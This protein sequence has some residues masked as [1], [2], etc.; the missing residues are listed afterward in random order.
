MVPVGCAELW[1]FLCL[2][3]LVAGCC[4][5]LRPLSGGVWSWS[6]GRAP[7]PVGVL[8]GMRWLCVILLA[9]LFGLG[10]CFFSFAP[11]FPWVGAR[12]WGFGFLLF[13][14]DIPFRGYP[15]SP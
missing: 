3:N 2:G 6:L 10:G 5:C 13:L 9:L 15:P 1:A 14:V 12:D 8:P 4:S 7:F 11:G